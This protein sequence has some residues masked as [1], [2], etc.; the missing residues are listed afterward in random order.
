MPTPFDFAWFVLLLISM[1]IGGKLMVKLWDNGVKMQKD[2]D[3]IWDRNG[4]HRPNR[5]KSK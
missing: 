5:K 3:K 2:T 4:W 1:Y